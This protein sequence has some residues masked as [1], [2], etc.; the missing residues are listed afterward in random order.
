MRAD[1]DGKIVKWPI[2]GKGNFRFGMTKEKR[3]A[4]HDHISKLMEEVGNEVV[5]TPFG[6]QFIDLPNAMESV[7]SV[8]KAR[9]LISKYIIDTRV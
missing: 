5:T 4:I 3:D 1:A 2:V 6:R 7:F 9:G 8:A